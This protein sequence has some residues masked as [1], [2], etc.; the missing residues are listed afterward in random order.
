VTL[1]KTSLIGGGRNGAFQRIMIGRKGF[2]CSA[3]LSFNWD[4]RS[5]LSF[6]V[7][8]SFQKVKSFLA[9]GN[10]RSCR[11]DLH[12]PFQVVGLR[13]PRDLLSKARSLRSEVR[14]SPRKKLPWSAG[15]PDISWLYSHFNS[16]TA[17]YQTNY[18]R[19]QQKIG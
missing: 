12:R 2:L 8:S 17:N 13:Y 7:L 11:Q 16:L 10:H 1:S 4:R 19:T 15:N 6:T 5:T 18:N 9:A 3:K 14:W